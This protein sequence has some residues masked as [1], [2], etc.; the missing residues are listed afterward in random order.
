MEILKERLPSGLT[1]ILSPME[2][3]KTITEVFMTRAGLINVRNKRIAK[4]FPEL[5]WWIG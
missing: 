5:Y 2:G 3:T 4:D 1:V